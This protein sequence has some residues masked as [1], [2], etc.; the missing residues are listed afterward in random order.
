MNTIIMIVCFALMVLIQFYIITRLKNKDR[1]W[2]LLLLCALI[3]V[4]G[5]FSSANKQNISASEQHKVS[6][7]YD[8]IVEINGE[9]YVSQTEPKIDYSC[10]TVEFESNEGEYKLNFDELS[11]TVIDQ[12]KEQ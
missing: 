9:S 1:L 11:I 8:F 10:K 7:K 6:Q 4:S 3:T 12:A 2:A 5:T